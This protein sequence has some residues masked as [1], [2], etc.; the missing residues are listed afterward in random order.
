MQTSKFLV[1]DKKIQILGNKIFAKAK[2]I[3]L[4][5]QSVTMMV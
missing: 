5:V 3:L 1:L 4:T 2:K